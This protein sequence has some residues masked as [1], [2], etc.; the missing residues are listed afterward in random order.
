[1]TQFWTINGQTYNHGQLMELKRKKLNPKTARAE[2]VAPE[3]DHVVTEKDL[4]LNPDL[5]GAVEVGET[6]SIPTELPTNFMQLKKLARE[7]GMNV[8][9]DTKKEEI[10]AFLNQ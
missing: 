7:K 4:E 9:S 8:T 10:I 3:V 6:V 5:Q 1:M 2:F